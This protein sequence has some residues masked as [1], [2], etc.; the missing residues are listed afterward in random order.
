MLRKAA[1][2]DHYTLT[3]SKVYQDQHK[4]HCKDILLQN[5]MCNAT[6]DVIPYVWA[7][8]QDF[9][10]PD[11]SIKKQCRNGDEISTWMKDNEPKGT[12]RKSSELKQPVGAKLSPLP[13]SLGQWLKDLDDIKRLWHRSNLTA[14]AE[15]F[16]GSLTLH[17]TF[18]LQL[19][20]L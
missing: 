10:L 8:G 5:L 4:I 13:P 19:T 11:F 18:L 17:V 1:F 3:R 7:E 20:G 15:Q 9:P 16:R 14:S 12:R 2:P 6:V